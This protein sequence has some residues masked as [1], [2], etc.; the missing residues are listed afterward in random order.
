MIDY[1]HMHIGMENLKYELYV[2]DGDENIND[3]SPAA[4]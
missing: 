1:K 2:K 3:C 4:P